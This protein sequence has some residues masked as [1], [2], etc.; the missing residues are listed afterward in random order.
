M[1]SSIQYPSDSQIEE[2]YTSFQPTVEDL[3]NF[4]IHE[5]MYL[6]YLESLAERVGLKD[7]LTYEDCELVDK[8]TDKF[9]KFER[10]LV[11]WYFFHEF[12]L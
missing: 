1:A 11:W 12:N 6:K 7:F 3:N 4:L 9:T 2:S 5:A 10:D 8:N